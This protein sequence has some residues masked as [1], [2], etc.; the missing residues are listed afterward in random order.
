MKLLLERIYNCKKYCIGHLYDITSGKKKF[1]CDTIE[2]TD[3]GLSD[4]MSV[5]YI[6]K[7]KVYAETAIP[8]GVYNINLNIVSPKYGSKQF[9]KDTCKGCV[10]R[11]EN[12]KGYEGILVHCGNTEKDS[13]GCLIVGENKVVGKVINSKITFEKLMKEYLNP[14]K[15]KGEKVTLEIIRK[16]KL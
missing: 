7:L 13:A 11:L 2:D 9:Y 5:D 6:K 8:T 3:R 12:V 15:K 1:I 10:P 16:Y 4:S 14:C